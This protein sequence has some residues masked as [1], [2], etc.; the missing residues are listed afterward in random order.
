MV[1]RRTGSGPHYLLLRYTAGHWDF[2][3]GNVE[4]G[5]RAP[6][7]AI[8]EIH[9]ETGIADV[10][11]VAEFD[12]RITYFYRRGG[13]LVH[14]EV[15]F[16]LGETKAEQV[17]LSAE[18]LGYAWLPFDRAMKRLT[19]ENARAILLAAREHLDRNRLG[20]TGSRLDTY[21]GGDDGSSDP[22]R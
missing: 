13:E 4:Q 10:T 3:K 9:E 22:G 7:T 5:E 2:P 8:R 21:A 1:F 16:L 17:R 19:F 14:K 12:R 15:E 20:E 18:H 6:E 11:L